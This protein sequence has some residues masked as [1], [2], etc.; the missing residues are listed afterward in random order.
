MC[1]LALVVSGNRSVD[2]QV[3]IETRCVDG[4]KVERASSVW[5]RARSHQGLPALQGKQGKGGGCVNEPNWAV[6]RA[7]GQQAV[8]T[9]KDFYLS[10]ILDFDW[11][12]CPGG[13]RRSVLLKGKS[14]QG[15]AWWLLLY[16][17]LYL[18]RGNLRVAEFVGVSASLHIRNTIEVKHKMLFSLHQSTYKWGC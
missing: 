14:H 2:H 15:T 11:M 7:E 12:V 4:S 13:G 10:G 1:C 6:V 17:L 8:T 18:V 3:V 5:M 9:G 16:R